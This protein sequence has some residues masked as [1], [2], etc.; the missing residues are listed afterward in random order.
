MMGG[1]AGARL[2]TGNS[3]IG[4]KKGAAGKPRPLV[5]YGIQRNLLFAARLCDEDG[6]RD[7]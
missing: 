4:A 1:R 3:L 6:I 7:A 2:S 5:I